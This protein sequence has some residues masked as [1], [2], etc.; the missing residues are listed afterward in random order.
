MLLSCLWL[1]CGL[2][3]VCLWFACGLLRTCNELLSYRVYSLVNLLVAARHNRLKDRPSKSR[4]AVACAVARCRRS[5]A[6][7]NAIATHVAP[8]RRRNA[9]IVVRSA[10]AATAARRANLQRGPKEGHLSKIRVLYDRSAPEGA[11]ALTDQELPPGMLGS[12]VGASTGSRRPGRQQEG[13]LLQDK[14]RRKSILR[15]WGMRA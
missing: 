13:G 9:S 2:L 7:R 14:V 10:H 6:T 8:R 5:K 11:T 1:A 3:I 15:W 4:D 12:T